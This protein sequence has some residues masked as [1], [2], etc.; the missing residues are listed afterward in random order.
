MALAIPPIRGMRTSL[1]VMWMI[2]TDLI[3]FS[4]IAQGR[5]CVK[6]AGGKANLVLLL[7]A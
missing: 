4:T 2:V 7:T 1:V 6:A 5:Q 3:I